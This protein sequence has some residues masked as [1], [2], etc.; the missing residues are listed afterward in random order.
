MNQHIVQIYIALLY[1][2]ISKP[3][4]FI[5]I[6]LFLSP[7]TSTVEHDLRAAGFLDP[8][9][10]LRAPVGRVPALRHRRLGHCHHHAVVGDERVH[11][12][13]DQRD[14]VVRLEPTIIGFRRHVWSFQ[15]VKVESNSTKNSCGRLRTCDFEVEKRLRD[16]HSP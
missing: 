8:L 9:H 13:F 12:L 16:I 1:V 3:Y 6:D 10:A 15:V 4:L 2:W 5:H 14:G 7:R 11:P